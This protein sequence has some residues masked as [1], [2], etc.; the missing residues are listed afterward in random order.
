MLAVGQ[1]GVGIEHAEF[2]NSLLF[3]AQWAEV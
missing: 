2:E 1:Q 3:E